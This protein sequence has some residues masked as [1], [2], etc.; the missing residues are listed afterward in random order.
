MGKQNILA[1]L[2]HLALAIAFTI[3]LVPSIIFFVSDYRHELAAVS[4]EAEIN[5]RI[6]G[7]LIQSNPDLWIYET[8]RLDELLARRSLQSVNR[9]EI[10]S[11]FGLD[12]KLVAESKDDLRL[13]TISGST[14]LYDAGREI[15]RI[16][17]TRSLRP[18]LIKALV[19]LLG[20][21]LFG[22]AVF[23]VIRTIP[24]NALNRAFNELAN[25]KEK[26]QI[27]LRSIG[28]AVITTDADMRIDY[29]NP[30]AERLIGWTASQ[31]QG[32]HI[33]EIL[34]IYNEMLHQPTVNPIRECFENDN[35]EIKN[36]AILVRN[37]DQKEFHIENFAAPIR[38]TDGKILGAV[39]VFHD[40]TD[41]KVAQSR[42]QHIAFHDSLTGLP[43]RA[44]FRTK[45]SD[46]LM[47]ARALKKHVSV[48]FL[49][50]DRFK[51]INDSLGHSV[52]D[53]LL[54]LVAKRL[55]QCVR[56]TDVVCRMGGDEFTAVLRSINT[57]DDAGVVAE[58]IIESIAQPFTIQ[59]HEL[60]ISTSIGITVYPEDGEDLDDLLKQ[61]DAA[62]YQAKGQGRNNHQYF[63]TAV[64]AK[65]SH[66]MQ[67]ETALQTAFE[68]NEFFLEYQPKLNLEHN[69]IVGAEALLRW[70]SPV[71]GH[72]VPLEFIRRLEESGAILQVGNWVLNTAIQQAKKWHDAGQSIAVAV[73]VSARQFKQDGLVDQIATMLQQAGLP[74]SLLQVEIAESLLMDDAER[75]EAVMRKLI[76]I[77]VNLSLDDFGTGYSSLSYLRRFP[78]NEIK[79]DRSFVVD[80][81]TNEMADNIIKTVI[82]LG[83]ALGMKVTAEGVETDK[84]RMHLERLG[85]DEIQ[86]YLLSPPLQTDAF[87]TFIKK[88]QPSNRSADWRNF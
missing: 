77:G 68:N 52:G 35:S 31:V 28:D 44:L 23:Y 62:M 6:V 14:L 9:K 36:H 24:L 29:L 38:S 54:I 60:R 37:T 19:I 70:Q 8:L 13:P 39:M 11:I 83:Q 2:T 12:K 81:G 3:A 21:S 64:S 73:N 27:T 25:E 30:I 17:V 66:E 45:L 40:V 20:S 51:N 10:R 5:S 53:E 69:Q 7:Q 61:A 26:A 47:D 50:L 18:A 76:N 16:E 57:M 33:D 65:V 74:P 48:L 42:L 79:I 78:I 55:E 80:M 43:N 58:K 46:A 15:G 59:G 88:L 41:Q 63:N 56:D 34:N 1:I 72:V 87:E 84:Q 75:S 49:D 4:I 22:I 32:R 71:F 86:G 82:E 67:L 85:C